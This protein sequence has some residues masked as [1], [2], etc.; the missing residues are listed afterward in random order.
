MYTYPPTSVLD[1]GYVDS[2]REGLSAPE[3][4]E[5]GSFCA[6]VKLLS[7]QDNGILPV[8]SPKCLRP[9]ERIPASARGFK[10]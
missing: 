9:G 3:F 1:S 8:K 7:H 4:M 5:R 10:K 2:G 6:P